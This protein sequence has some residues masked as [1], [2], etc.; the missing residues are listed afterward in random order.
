[1]INPF[2]TFRPGWACVKTLCV[3][4]AND[5]HVDDRVFS[6]QEIRK[7]RFQSQLSFGEQLFIA[8]GIRQLL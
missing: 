5:L 8:G 1:M 3:R 4:L 7:W 2:L 6:H